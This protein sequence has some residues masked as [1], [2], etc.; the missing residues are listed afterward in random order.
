MSVNVVADRISK[1]ERENKIILN[2]IKIE[3]NRIEY[4]YSV[5][6]TWRNCFKLQNRF[7]IEY[8]MDFD[9]KIP[10][11]VAVIPFLGNFLPVSWVFNAEIRIDEIDKEY[12]YSIDEIKRGYQLMYPNISFKGKLSFGKAVENDISSN[13]D[14]SAL[15]FS[16]GVDAF[17]SLVH[18]YKE[19]PMLLTVWGTDVYLKDVDGWEAISSNTKKVAEDFDLTYLFIKTSF[20]E[21]INYQFLNDKIAKPNHEN[22][23]HGFQHG[24]A[25]IAHSAPVSF[26]KNIRRIYFSSTDSVKSKVPYTCASHLE[27]DNN[28]NNNGA[29]TIHEGFEDTRLDKIRKVCRFFKERKQQISLHVCWVTRDGKNCCRCEKCARTIFGIMAEG[30]DP[31]EFGFDL[32][33]KKYDELAKM[34]KNEE[35]PIYPVF[36]G[37]IA[38]GLLSQIEKPAVKSNEAARMILHKVLGETDIS[39]RFY[40]TEFNQSEKNDCDKKS[41]IILF[42][43]EYIGTEDRTFEAV[44]GNTG[45]M[46]YTKALQSILDLTT[47]SYNNAVDSKYTPSH[48]ITTDLIWIN[49]NSNFDYLISQMNQFKEAIFVPISVG[50]QASKIGDDFKLN[51]GTLRVLNMIQERA[52]IGCRGYYTAD[53]LQKNGIKN[54]EV[55]GCPS[56]YLK[57]KKGYEIKR[58]EKETNEIRVVSNFRTFYGKLSIKE[59][60]FLSYCADRNFDFVEQTKFNFDLSHTEGD[61]K[62]FNYVNRW[63]TKNSHTFFDVDQWTH[64]VSVHDFSFGSRFHGN[65][66]ALWN[67]IPALF[68]PIDSRMSEL[69]EFFRLPH[70]SMDEFDRDRSIK[71]Y[72]EKADYS[73]FEKL[74]PAYFD[75]FINFLEKNGIELSE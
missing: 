8:S 43:H 34:I 57:G 38:N 26:D 5:V 32:S 66:L 7:F 37:D 60:H 28:N 44:A 15:F 74:Y 23:W 65:V 62:Y 25:L 22:W 35:L 47:T 55:I 64:Y 68:L 4:D 12:L 48:I 63:M 72:I 50:L 16:G 67:D 61:E 59:K 75:K 21:V 30:Y 46:V 2:D 1:I 31:V 51:D 56:I 13:A 14:Q 52:V 10:Y 33:Q 42:R 39:H 36:W 27:M 3:K 58:C 73:E 71:Y 17:S 24:M 69:V 18:I 6:G 19:K 41:E 29:R 54:I 70:I 49:P 45:N 9:K 53:I 11:S 20:R 40:P